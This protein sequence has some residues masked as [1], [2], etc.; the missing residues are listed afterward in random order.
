MF[1][2]LK[3]T[4]V[5]LNNHQNKIYQI[6]HPGYSTNITTADNVVLNFDITPFKVG[7]NT[8]D[9]LAYHVNNTAIENIRNVFLE[10]NNHDKNLGPLVDTLKKV[11]AGNYSST[12][13]YL[14][15]EGKWEINLTVQRIGEY[16]INQR[17]DADVK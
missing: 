2:H 14:S 13:S 11:G 5:K 7:S 16:D 4:V 10:L 9:L 8:F 17:I 1:F 3:V 15:Q 6:Y 12:G